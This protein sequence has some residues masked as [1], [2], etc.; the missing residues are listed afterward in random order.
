LGVVNSTDLRSQDRSADVRTGLTDIWEAVI[1]PWRTIEPLISTGDRRGGNGSESSTGSRTHSPG[2]RAL[3]RID[4]LRI[5]ESVYRKWIHPK[6]THK[7]FSRK[8]PRSPALDEAVVSGAL[9]R[10][11]TRTPSQIRSS[12]ALP[13]IAHTISYDITTFLVEMEGVSSSEHKRF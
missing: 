6:V 13:P 10:R 2:V 9:A 8:A 3:K 12:P 4:S 5:V 11:Q 7:C 1:D